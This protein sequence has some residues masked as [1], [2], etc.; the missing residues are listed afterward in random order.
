MIISAL[1]HK[2]P[3]IYNFEA[4]PC[5]SI[6]VDTDGKGMAKISASALNHNSLTNI[7][8]YSSFDRAKEVLQLIQDAAVRG[9]K[10]FVLPIE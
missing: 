7:A 1:Y 8:T 5:L 6:I 4:I 2:E 9:E 3:R 10:V